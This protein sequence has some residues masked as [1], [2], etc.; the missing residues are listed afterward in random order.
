ML[1][2]SLQVLFAD[3][4]SLIV[5]I[6]PHRSVLTFVFTHWFGIPDVGMLVAG[7]RLTHRRRPHALVLF[8][9]GGVGSIDVRNPR[10]AAHPTR[11]LSTSNN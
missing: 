4:L 11:L 6:G 9:L 3:A 1:D 10:P 8:H 5:L 7:S 2:R